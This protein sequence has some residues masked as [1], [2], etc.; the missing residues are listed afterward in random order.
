MKKVIVLAAGGT[1]KDAARMSLWHGFR[2]LPVTEEEDKFG[3]RSLSRR[4]EPEAS[5][6]GIE[7]RR[8]A[9]TLVELTTFVTRVGAALLMGV[10]IGI[11]RQFR[12]HPGGLRINALVCVAQPCSSHLPAWL[13]TTTP[14]P[15]A[16][17]PTS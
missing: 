8:T 9:V 2:A 11:E 7:K 13:P 6:S 17:P 15:A 10:A 14:P 3:H 12:Q 5:Q 4:D 16:S 1:L